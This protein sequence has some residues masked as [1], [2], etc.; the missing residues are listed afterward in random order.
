[1]HNNPGQGKVNTGVKPGTGVKADTSVQPQPIPAPVAQ[2]Q[3][4]PVVQQLAPVA[5]APMPIMPIMPVAEKQPSHEAVKEHEDLFKQYPVPSVQA[6]VHADKSMP[7]DYGMQPM[8]VNE[9]H[10]DAYINYETGYG[11]GMQPYQMSPESMKPGY[12][13]GYGF[14]QQGYG[15]QGYGQQGY[16][17]QGY[18]QQSVISPLG[19][20][21]TGNLGEV[22]GQQ[23]Y[24]YSPPTNQAFPGVTSP[25]MANVQ[26]VSG[27]KTCGGPP[28][29]SAQAVTNP[30]AFQYSESYPGMN[31][32]TGAVP[33]GVTPFAS[34]SYGNMPQSVSPFGNYPGA[35]PG[36]YYG[37]P[38]GDIPIG[39]NPATAGMP[40]I[41]AVPYSEP[42]YGSIP[43]IPPMPPMP[44]MPPLGP[45]REE[46][47]DD[48]FDD[49]DQELAIKSSAVKKRQAKPKPRAGAVRQSKP[50]RKENLPW[51][52]W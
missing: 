52:K 27:C 29:W 1:M 28:S 30:G 36:G 21:I 38:M 15:Q 2:P 13:H 19:G 6:T 33:Y 25:Y 17:Q 26:P 46:E 9:E 45:L 18:N 44:P 40:G 14:G 24:S 49:I 37:M 7:Y 41:G 50:R 23:D 3:P 31:Q 34:N 4:A 11:Q 42:Y 22:Y 43:A 16:G 35:Q 12:G 8:A 32:P 10:K 51:I 20:Q 5:P 39:M 47:R 48:R